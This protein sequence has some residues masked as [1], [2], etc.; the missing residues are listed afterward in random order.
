MISIMQIMIDRKITPIL[1]HRLTQY[2]AVVLVGPRQAGKTTLARSLGGHYCDLE[3]ESERL[4]LD[5]QFQELIQ[6]NELLILDE[7][8]SWPAIFPR[9]RRAI[10]ERPQSRGRFLLLGSVS[11]ALMREVSES[12]AGRLSLVELSPFSVS[13]LPDT[14]V[15]TLWHVGGYPEG[16]GLE[17]SRYP[18][19]QLDYLTML[20]LRDFPA[21]GLPAK[22]Q[23]IQR[24]LKMVAAVHGQVW[25]ASQ[26]G[27]ALGLSY[28]TVN[29]YMDY[30]VGAFLVRRLPPYQANIKKRLVKSPK[31]YWRD[32]GL[33]HAILNGPSAEELLSS[34]W[35]GASWEGFVIEQL[36]T[37]FAHEGIRAEP[38]FFRTSDRRELDF[39][40]EIGGRLWA[41]EIKLTSSPDV[42]D[43]VRLNRVSDLIGADLRILVSHAAE[44]RRDGRRVS[45]NLAWLLAHLE[46]L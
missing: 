24:L 32:P 39:V 2:A 7:A 41:L 9:L 33:L 37:A 3:Q 17:A 46:D 42:E 19:W 34:P 43:M 12:L 10:D 16:G 5:L 40:L 6:G 4:R 11:P 29:D 45:C 28:H 23:V 13:E 8:Q 18:Q 21:W 30:L 44:C 26:L 22:P 36:L 31:F 1:K 27:S 20:A 15:E 38:F 14:A 25:N 35:V